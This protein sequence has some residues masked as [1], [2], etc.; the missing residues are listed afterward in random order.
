MYP[1]FDHWAYVDHLLPILTMYS[2]CT[3]W[4]FGPLPPVS[5]RHSLRG[6]RELFLPHVSLSPHESASTDSPTIVTSLEIL[7]H[8][9]VIEDAKRKVEEYQEAADRRARRS[10][11]A[12]GKPCF[13]VVHLELTQSCD[14]SGQARTILQSALLVVSSDR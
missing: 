9:A 2:P 13:L 1:T 14:A 4:V 8:L 6:S 7:N 12:H 3:H 10:S 11:H 5:P